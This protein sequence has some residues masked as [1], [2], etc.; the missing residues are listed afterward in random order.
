[1]TRTSIPAARPRA[2]SATLR[3][4]AVDGDDQTGAGRRRRLDRRRDRPWPSSSRRG[5]YGSG[6]MPQAPEG[7]DEDREPGQAVRVEVAEDHDASRRRLGPSGSGRGSAPAS[8]SRRGS[9]SAVGRLG[10]E[11]RELG[12]A[13]P[14]RGPRGGRSRARRARAGRPASRSSA[15]GATASATRQAKRGSITPVRMPRLGHPD[16]PDSA[17]RLR[18]AAGRGRRPAAASGGDAARSR[19]ARE[20]AGPAEPAVLPLVPHDEQRR[21]VEDRR[22]RPRD[23]PDQEGEHEVPDRRAAEQVAATAASGRP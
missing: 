15:V 14:R 2:I 9:W 6:S 7:A 17:R 11:R 5:T 12:C 20:R 18:A 4:A 23:D 8:G 19:G 22:V 21:G 16:S 3:R 10:E 1:M 13:S